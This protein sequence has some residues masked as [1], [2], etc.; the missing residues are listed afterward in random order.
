MI[1][2]CQKKEVYASL[3]EVQRM[4]MRMSICDVT[5]VYYIYIYIYISE[6]QRICMRLSICGVTTVYTYI[7]IYIY[8]YIYV[9]IVYNLGLYTT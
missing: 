2:D 8:I 3:S 4:C 5:T 9:Y 6:D 7:Y 1:R